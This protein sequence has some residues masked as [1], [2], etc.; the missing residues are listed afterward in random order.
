MLN[1]VLNFETVEGAI[2]L[3]GLPLLFVS[4]IF[5]PIFILLYGLEKEEKKYKKYLEEKIKKGEP[6]V[7]G[8]P[9]N[10]MLPHISLMNTTI[11]TNL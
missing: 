7:S 2:L 9:A 4:I 1:V 5:I 8:A 6:I 10:N 11:F 3:I